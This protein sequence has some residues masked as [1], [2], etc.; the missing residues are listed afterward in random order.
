MRF[1][2]ASYKGNYPPGTVLDYIRFRV[3]GSELRS[4]T[5]L[6]F[7]AYLRFRIFCLQEKKDGP[8]RLRTSG[9]RIRA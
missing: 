7:R 2:E 6:W 5:G 4:Y 1:I 3:Y 8:S 9:S